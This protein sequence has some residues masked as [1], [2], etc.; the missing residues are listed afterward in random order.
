MLR[1]IKKYPVSLTFILVVVYLSF[2]KPP[3][4]PRITLFPHADK[5]AHAGMYFVMSALLWWEF[6][7]NHKEQVNIRHAWAGAFLFPVLFSGAVELLQEYCT[8]HRG[9]DWLDF[10]AN[11]VGIALTSLIAHRLLCSKIRK[12]TD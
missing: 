3:S 7:R 2:L 11:T 1:Y 12:G 4:V 6:R 9:G 8:T 5:V 10:L